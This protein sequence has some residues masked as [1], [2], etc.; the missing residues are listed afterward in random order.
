MLWTLPL[1]SL[2]CQVP[3]DS[4]GWGTLAE[5]TIRNQKSQ[6]WSGIHLHRQPFPR[7]ILC[8]SS[9]LGRWIQYQFWDCGKWW[10]NICK[11]NGIVFPQ[12]LVLPVPFLWWFWSWVGGWSSLKFFILWIFQSILPY[13]CVCLLDCKSLRSR[14]VFVYI[15]LI[16]QAHGL[17]GSCSKPSFRGKLQVCKGLSWE[18]LQLRD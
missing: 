16:C 13:L 8:R 3:R 12:S 7:Q 6:V 10:H 4:N 15:F 14:T 9:A 5:Q 17:C 11:V 18:I 2:F 1:A